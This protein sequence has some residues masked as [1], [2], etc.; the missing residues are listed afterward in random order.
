MTNTL[1][2]DTYYRNYRL[3]LLSEGTPTERVHIRVM[4]DSELLSVVPTIDKAKSV[5]DEWMDA[6]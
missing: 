5:I 4:G 2:R 3:S 1:P 6:K